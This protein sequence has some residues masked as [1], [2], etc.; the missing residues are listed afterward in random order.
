V[1]SGP[2]QSTV[3]AGLGRRSLAF[4]LDCIV[5]L[6]AISWVAA[7]IPEDASVTTIG[8][9]LL[10]LLNIGFNYFWLAEWRFGRTI[11]KAAAGIRVTSESGERPSWNAGALRNLLRLVDVIVIGPILIAASRRKQRLGDRAGHTIVVRDVAGEAAAEATREAARQR[12]AVRPALAGGAGPETT[13]A[14]TQ[15]PASPGGEVAPKATD[16]VGIPAGS[17][18]PAQVVYGI[19]AVIGLLLVESLIVAIF[20]PDLESLGADLALQA[21]LA[22][23]LVGVAIAF[24]GGPKAI[25]AALGRLGLRRFKRS[26]LWLALATYGGYIVISLVLSPLLHP[27]QE[28]V[29]RDLGYGQ[30]AFGAVAAGLLIVCAAPIS[31]ELFFR[32][33]VFGGI[34]RRLPLWPAAAISGAIFGL[35]HLT[36][37]SIGVA[38][39]LAVFGM[40]LAWLYEYTGA[41]WPSILTHAINNTLAFIIV[42]ST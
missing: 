30:S 6:V 42:V 31:E 27:D 3:Y 17:W 22:L 2:T 33:F 15:M 38:V 14:A 13:L 21:L 26:G 32:G 8:I 12:Y 36:A 20:D 40:L 16:G 7:L 23:T 10:I 25:A 11:G 37:G 4:A 5:W 28:D 18:S 29:A 39:Q 34:R 1:N 9:V 41:L 35:V 19:L 24:A